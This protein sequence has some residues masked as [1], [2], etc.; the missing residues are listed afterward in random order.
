MCLADYSLLFPSREALPDTEDS[1]VR[2]PIWTMFTPD[3]RQVWFTCAGH[4]ATLEH[5]HPG[6]VCYKSLVRTYCGFCPGP[7]A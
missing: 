2:T 7:S 6:L 5:E 1:A 4:R 3:R